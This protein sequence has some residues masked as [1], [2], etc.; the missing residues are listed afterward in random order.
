MQ[1]RKTNLILATAVATW[2][3]LTAGEPTAAATVTVSAATGYSSEWVFRGLTLGH[4]GQQSSLGVD[5]QA[6]RQLSVGASA[7]NW[8]PYR[9]TREHNNTN[10]D[11]HL[12]FAPKHLPFAVG[13][14]V[15][16]YAGQTFHSLKE[17]YVWVT[18]TTLPGTPTLQLF[19]ELTGPAHVTA[20]GS[21]AKGWQ[22]KHGLSY[23]TWGAVGFNAGARYAPN[24]FAVAIWGHNLTKPLPY[25]LALTG[26]VDVHVPSHRYNN[27]LRF[28]PGL[29]LGWKHTF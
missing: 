17:G 15:L 19:H 27:S 13:G 12:A 2:S 20:V 1:R 7:W 28:V 5:V 6:T 9:G 14:G 24:G 22:L 26:T 21:A 25:G 10:L 18:A 4:G 8:T 23:T 3:L 16:D 29:N 11:V